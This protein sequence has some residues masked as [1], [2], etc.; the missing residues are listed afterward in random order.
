VE[1]SEE[2]LV[3]GVG[4]SEWIRGTRGGTADHGGMVM[5]RAGY[6]VS[7]GVFPARPCGR[8]PLPAEY[9]AVVLDSGVPR[10]YDD[11]VKEETVIAYPLGT[12]MVRELLLPRMQG[13]PGFEGLVPDFRQRLALIRDITQQNLGIELPALYRL[14]KEL[15]VR[16]TLRELEKR[17]VAANAQAAYQ[18][19]YRLQVQG[20]FQH[21]NG[22]FPVFLRRRFCFGLA[23]QDRVRGALEYMN[24]GDLATV[25]EL[26]RISHEGDLDREVTDEDLEERRTRAARGEPRARLCFLPGGYG[27]MTPQYDRVVRTINEYLLSQGGPEAGAVQRLGAGWGGNLGGL[28]RREF[29]A[30]KRSRDFA[31]LLREELDLEADLEKCM[32]APG[33]GACLLEIGEEVR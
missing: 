26:V 11:A 4:T 5:G 9:A 33:Q 3:D 30:G 8:A 10:V 19:M 27:R 22:D 7:V 1:L 14:L 2:D 12:F 18:A 25:L 24:G 13:Q 29:I 17:A 15:P 31:R 20:K 28:V 23:E 16:I 6:L 32:A 21:V